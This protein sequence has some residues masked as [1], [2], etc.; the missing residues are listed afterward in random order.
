VQRSSPTSEEEAASVEYLVTMTTRVPGGTSEAAIA[1]VR[2]REAEHSLDLARQGF[3]LRLWRPPLQPGEWRTFG[4]FAAPDEE[5]L[6]SGLASMPLRVWRTDE[7]TPL[8][9]HPNDPPPEHR[10]ARGPLPEFFTIFTVLFAAG[11]PHETVQEV[12]AAEAENS[13]RLGIAGTLARLWRLPPEAG[14]S[15][16]LGLWRTP[17]ARQMQAILDALPMAPWLAVETMPLSPHPSDPAG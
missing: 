1:D 5:K 16:A 8:A 13:R 15:R 9:P 10:Q 3:L 17:D 11:T 12:T 4:L 2:A 7:V 14:R 6:E